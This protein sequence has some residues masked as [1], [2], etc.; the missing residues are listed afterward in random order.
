MND[1]ADLGS[2]RAVKGAIVLQETDIPDYFVIVR[3]KHD[4]RTWLETR[5]CDGYTCSQFMSS[6]R[7]VPDACIEGPLDHA[8][9][10]ALA[11]KARTS[12]H[13]KRCAVQVNDD[14]VLLWSPKNSST[15]AEVPLSVADAMADAFLQERT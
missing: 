14:R 11:I 7:L 10:L 12:A 15:Y 1:P 2:W 5:E 4:G 9:A 6:E 13:F 8:T 3:E